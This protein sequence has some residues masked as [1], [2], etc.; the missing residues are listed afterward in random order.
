VTVRA[1]KLRLA[2][3]DAVYIIVLVLT[4]LRRVLLS[5]LDQEYVDCPED[6]DNRHLRNAFNY[7]P[8]YTINYSKNVDSSPAPL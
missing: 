6:G 8:L 5:S 7:V 2:G 3:C 4:L 1:L